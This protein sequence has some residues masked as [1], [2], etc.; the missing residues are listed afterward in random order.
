MPR[1]MLAARLQGLESAGLVVRRVNDGTIEYEPTEALLAL[2]DVIVGLGLWARKW[3]HRGFK[4]EELDPALLLW[5]MQRRMDTPRLPPDLVVVRFDFSDD[6]R[7]FSHYWLKI[8]NRRA[9]VCVI[10]PGF[11]EVLV[12]R[13]A[14]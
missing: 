14:T 5:D 3:A 12:V 9:E 6:K 8:E 2:G 1:S 7:G 13:T 4:D 10:H 11:E